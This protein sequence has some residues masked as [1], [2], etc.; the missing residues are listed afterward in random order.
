MQLLFICT[1]N[2]CRSPTAERLTTAWSANHGIH[3]LQASSAGT[4]AVVGSGM[5]P[6]AAQFLSQLGGHPDGFVARRLTPAI[7]AEADLIL[8]MTEAHRDAVLR[9]SPR[10]LKRTFTLLEAAHLIRAAGSTTVAEMAD[11]RGRIPAPPGGANVPDPIGRSASVFED[12][13]VQ[14][15]EALLTVLTGLA[16]GRHRTG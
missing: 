12:V 5:E 2:I 8:T 15:S 13:S 16:D 9:Q 7:A 11:A 4:H 3:D 6:T 1:G 14:I 10:Q